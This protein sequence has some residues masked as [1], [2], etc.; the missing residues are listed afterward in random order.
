MVPQEFSSKCESQSFSLYKEGGIEITPVEANFRG[1]R[2]PICDIKAVGLNIIEASFIRKIEVFALRTIG[3]LSALG[4]VLELSNDHIG[5]AVLC[6][7]ASLFCFAGASQ[8]SGPRRKYRLKIQT[9]GTTKLVPVADKF[10]MK[11]IKSA[12]E[13]ATVGDW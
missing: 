12:I 6:A 4:V 10:A 7:I 13:R 3:V 8:E 2:L 9:G 1:V 11:A 5:R